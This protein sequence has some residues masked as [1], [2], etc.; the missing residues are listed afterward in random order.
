MKNHFTLIYSINQFEDDDIKLFDVDELV[1]DE[2]FTEFD[3]VFDYLD[4]YQFEPSMQVVN[5]LVNFSS[6]L[7]A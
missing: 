2:I 7:D 4:Q 6:T 1:S 3:D 5:N